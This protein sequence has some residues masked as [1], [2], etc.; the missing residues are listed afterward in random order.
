MPEFRW[1]HMSHARRI[2][3]V[4]ECIR[5]K[6]KLPGIAYIS[7]STTETIEEFVREHLPNLANLLPH[8]RWSAADIERH[9]NLGAEDMY[10]PFCSRF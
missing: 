7:D 8:C 10:P 9:K 4:S 2:E 5:C 1:S 3:Y 6:N